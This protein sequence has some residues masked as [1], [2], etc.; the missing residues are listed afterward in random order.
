MKSTSTRRTVLKNIAAGAG[1]LS[2][3]LSM[4]KVMAASENALGPKLNGKINH[5]VCRW[6]YSKIPLET[7]AQEAK[8]IGLKSIELVRPGR[9]AGT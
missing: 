4:T 9:M 8:K 5:S 7:L 3:P 2:L 1:I 6:C